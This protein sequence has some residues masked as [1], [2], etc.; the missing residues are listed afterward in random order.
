MLSLTL[1][2]AERLQPRDR[3]ADQAPGPRAEQF[4]IGP[5]RRVR[6][7]SVP[8]PLDGVRPDVR[9]HRSQLAPVFVDQKV[10]NGL[11]QVGAKTALLRIRAPEQPAG[12]HD[13]FEKPLRQIL[14]VAL[15]PD[16]RRNEGADGRVVAVG[17]L[18][19][20][21]R[22][23]V[24]AARRF[25]EEIPGRQGKLLAYPLRLLLPVFRGQRT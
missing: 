3:H 18:V 12:K 19:E 4:R 8:A 10:S 20:G 17:E 2:V 15:V 22:R 21:P 5:R 11:L 25:S 13:R 24:A 23:L 16:Q 9:A 1:L 6:R 7:N 14:G